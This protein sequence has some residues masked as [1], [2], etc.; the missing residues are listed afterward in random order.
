[1]NWNRNESGFPG[2]PAWL[3]VPGGASGRALKPVFLHYDMGFRSTWRGGTHHSFADSGQGYCVFNDVVVAARALQAETS[4]RKV[5]VIDLDV[6]QGNGTASLARDDPTL[7]AFSMHCGKNYPFRKSVG[8]LDVALPSGADDATYLQ[9]LDQALSDIDRVFEPEFVFFVA[10]ADPFSG[11]RLGL[12]Q[13]SKS[14]LRARDH[15]VFEFCLRRE[16]PVAI[17]MAGGYAPEVNDIVDIQFPDGSVGVVLPPH[18]R[19]ANAH[20]GDQDRRQIVG[21]SVQKSTE[22]LEEPA[23]ENQ[24]NRGHHGG[25]DHELTDINAG[26]VGL[27]G[28]PEVA[29]C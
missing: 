20:E 2:H 14:G 1:M 4:L 22:N 28:S 18:S 16:L 8:D 3:S 19:N 25:N 9:A 23:G 12:L 21:G 11:D 27:D 15:R 17:A 13:I 5:L 10:G 24:E 29:P 7:F 6:H 26:S